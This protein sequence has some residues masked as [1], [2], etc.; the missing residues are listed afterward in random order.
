MPR[1]ALADLGGKT[2]IVTGANT[3]IGREAALALA[4][5]GARVVLACRSETRGRAALEEI[6]RETRSEALE[7]ALVDLSSQASIRELARRFASEHDA[8][9]VLINNAGIYPDRREVTEDGIE[10]TWATNVLGYFLL[11]NLLRPLLEAS[12]PARVVNVAS[13]RAGGLDLGDVELERRRFGGVRAYSQSKQANR[14]L[15]WALD[16]RLAGTGI[17]VNVAHPGPVATELART[18]RGVLGFVVKQGFKLI[19]KTPA[20]GADTAVWLAASP[21]LAGVSGKFWANRRE[22]RCKFRDP[23]A[24]EALWSL[25]EQMVARQP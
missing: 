6:A 1:P 16:R 8:L 4:A 13:T 17:T 3:G 2:C 5:M 11:T 19:G 15:S 20:E 10:R 22:L 9:H 21:A 24:E 25:C 18:Q 7:L 12:S 23:A 14:M